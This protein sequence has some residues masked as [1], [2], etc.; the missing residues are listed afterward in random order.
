MG[1]Q[2]SMEWLLI[3]EPLFDDLSVSALMPHSMSL[4]AAMAEKPCSD[5][6]EDT[7]GRGL[8]AERL[9]MDASVFSSGML[10]LFIWSEPLLFRMELRIPAMPMCYQA[11]DLD[12]MQ[13][14][15]QWLESENDT[16]TECN[17]F[18]DPMNACQ[19]VVIVLTFD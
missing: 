2:A 4:D 14:N 15:K 5:D 16:L 17:V 13:S 6:M 9:P 10:R 12:V 7:E 18:N 8:I 1:E 11:S 3:I 19:S